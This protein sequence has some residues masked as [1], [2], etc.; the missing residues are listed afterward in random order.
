MGNRR[1]RLERRVL[2]AYYDPGSYGG[3]Q[4]L[5]KATGAPIKTLRYILQ[6]NLAYTLHKPV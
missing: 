1:Q 3:L 2:K 6:K 5:Q 4:R